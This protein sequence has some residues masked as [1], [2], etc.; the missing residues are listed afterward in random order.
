[1]LPR[2]DDYTTENLLD[3]S[4]HRNYY[5]LTGIDLLRQSKYE[6]SSTNYFC[7]KVEEHDGTTMLFIAEKQHKSI[8]NFSLDS[9][10]VT[11]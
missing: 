7:R 6:Y 5:R 1:M 8:L 4:H 2:N 10:I 11:G 3:F 9:L